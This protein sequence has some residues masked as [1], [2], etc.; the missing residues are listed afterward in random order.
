MIVFLLPAEVRR[1]SFCL[2]FSHQNSFFATSAANGCDLT[3]LILPRVLCGVAGVRVHY[4][5]A[6]PG[7]RRSH[8]RDCKTIIIIDNVNTMLRYD[9]LILSEVL[10]MKRSS[11]IFLQIVIVL[12][13]IA[14]LSF[15]CGSPH[16]GMNAHATNFEIYFKEPFLVLCT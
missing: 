1:N 7:R 11:T 3:Q 5:V 16:R 10:F 9:H 15:C 12:I 13:G 8:N 4:P 14:L 6:F 2:S